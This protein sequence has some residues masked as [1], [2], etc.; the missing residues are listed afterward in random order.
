[1]SQQLK[2]FIAVLCLAVSPA[3]SQAQDAE[4]AQKLANPIADLISIPFQL[5]H[6]RGFG[7][8]GDGS[9]T[10]LNIQPVYPFR[11]SDDWTLISRTILP[12]IWQEDVPTGTRQ[13]G[14]G[15]TLQSFFLSPR[16]AG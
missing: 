6:D 2:T 8:N 13:T 3:M 15:D 10:T 1:M 16:D 7:P 4:T 12:V 14:L 9:R 11:L 5:N